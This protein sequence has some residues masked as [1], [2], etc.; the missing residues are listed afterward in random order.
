MTIGQITSILGIITQIVKEFRDRLQA[1]KDKPWEPILISLEML[2]KLTSE[3]IKAIGIVTTPVLETGDIV[4]THENFQKL[5]NNPDFPTGYGTARGTLEAAYTHSS[6]RSI[7]FRQFEKGTTRDKLKKVLEEL[8]RFQH[9]AF[10]LGVDSWG[11]ADSLRRA[12]ELWSLLSASGQP[13]PDSKIADLQ[14]QVQNVFTDF[15]GWLAL[16]QEQ[17]LDVPQL[18]T[19]DDVVALVRTWGREWQRHVQRT[20]YGGRGLNHAIAQLRMEHYK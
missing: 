9:A 17:P 20:L 7:S 12:L 11:M 13:Q 3:H 14:T 4:S 8:G 19:P 15:F 5:V 10:M 16:Q 2:E 6:D 1:A 18:L